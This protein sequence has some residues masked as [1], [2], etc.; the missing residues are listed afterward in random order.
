MCRTAVLYW[1]FGSLIRFFFV[2]LFGEKF[3][4]LLCPPSNEENAVEFQSVG[5][6]FSSWNRHCELRM[7]A[8]MVTANFCAG[9]YEYAE[10]ARKLVFGTPCGY[11]VAKRAVMPSRSVLGLI[12]GLLSPM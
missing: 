10:N 7:I 9:K 2:S 5:L 1:I 12:N 6:A 3:S 11:E 4:S 8:F